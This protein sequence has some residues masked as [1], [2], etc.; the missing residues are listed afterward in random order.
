[1]IGKTVSHYKILDELGRGGMGI[2]YRGEDTRLGRSVALKFLPAERSRDPDA[3]QRFQREA[4]AASALNHPYICTVHDIGEHADRHFIVMEL[5]EGHTLKHHIASQRMQMTEILGLGIQVADALEAAHAKGIVHRD[6]K[7]GNIFRTERG[8]AK[9]LDFG[10]AKLLANDWAG[11]VGP[12]DQGVTGP[13]DALTQSGATVGTTAYMSPEQARGQALDARSDL[14]SLGA[15]LYEMVTGRRAFEGDNAVIVVDAILNRDPVP[16]GRLSPGLPPELERVIGKALEKDRELRY[17][18]AAELRVDLSRLA[19]DLGTPGSRGSGEGKLPVDGSRDSSDAQAASVAV[20]PFLNL[21]SDPENEYFADGI[22]EDVIA[23]L[24]K[25][26]SLKVISRTSV[27]PFKKREQSLRQIG[28]TLGTAKILDGSVRRAGNRVRIVAQLI[29]VASDENVWGETYDR[30]IT[31][32]FAIQT[33]VA[34]QIAAALRVGLSSGERARLGR[35]PT[36][37]L[38]AY[39][40]YLH[41]RRS[42]LKYT[43]TGLREA[44]KLFEQ[45]IARDPEFAL[46]HTSLALAYAEMGQGQGSG[47]MEPP[48]AFARAKEAVARALE[49]DDRLGEAHGVVGMLRFVCDFDWTRAEEAFT[50]ALELSPGS[51]DILDHYALMCSSLERYDDAIRLLERSMGLDPLAHRSDLANTL[52]R[53]GRHREA[54]E[55]AAQFLELEPSNSRLHAI[56]G[57]VALK[58]GDHAEGLAALERAVELEPGSTMFLGQLGQAY[59]LAGNGSKA[60]KIL[61]QMRELARERYVSPYHF[62]YVHT[63]LGEFDQAIDLLEQAFE[64]RAG[65]IYGIKGSFLFAG[66]RSHPRFVALLEKINLA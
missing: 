54:G 62:A 30:E 32:I 44:I 12:A 6:I 17:Q 34:L 23:H 28:T 31:D 8:E 50:L 37:D 64:Q 49:L 9:V 40:L 51:V 7:P 63:G 13:T 65:A 55:L 59:G 25:I 35:K 48:V 42:F 52:L 2:V 22:T 53:A 36:Q 47:A 16:A 57:W 66:L 29:D 43:E 3:V 58:S 4:R 46:A 39:Q 1:M 14:F 60:R 10:L 18:T 20:L 45:A 26:P 33:D 11:D 5:I 19:R 21:S 24:A 27:M 38:R 61:E 15:V 41:G 56:G